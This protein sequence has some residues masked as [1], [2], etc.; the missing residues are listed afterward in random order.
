MKETL[1]T[2]QH[3]DQWKLSESRGYIISDE[4]YIEPSFI[5]AYDWLV[6]KMNQLQ[7]PYQAK[8]PV[9]AWYRYDD[10]NRRPDLRSSGHFQKGE[11]AILIEF[12]T[13]TN[14]IL[15]S[16]FDEWHMVLNSSSDEIKTGYFQDEDVKY[17]FDNIIIKNK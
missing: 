5:I 17:Y 12:E 11:K 14:E 6:S 1:W 3:P 2:I 15:L 13:D 10:K 7:N 9:W 16:D 8:F 4:Q